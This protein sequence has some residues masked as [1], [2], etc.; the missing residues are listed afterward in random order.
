MSCR[1]LQGFSF[2]LSGANLAEIGALA[3]PS[4]G[5]FLTEVDTRHHWLETELTHDCSSPVS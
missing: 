5:K 4:I 3:S 1:P 2:I